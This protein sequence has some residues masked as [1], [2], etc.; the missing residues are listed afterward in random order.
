MLKYKIKSPSRFIVIPP[1]TEGDVNFFPTIR[2]GLAY[3]LYYIN[4]PLVCIILYTYLYT[5][6]N[7][8]YHNNNDDNTIYYYIVCTV[9]Y[10]L[11]I[12]YIYI[13][14]DAPRTGASAR[15]FASTAR[16]GPTAHKPAV[17]VRARLRRCT[18]SARPAADNV[19]RVIGPP[20]SGG[21]EVAR[22]GHVRS[23]Q[24][25]TISCVAIAYFPQLSLI[26]VPIILYIIL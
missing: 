14:A 23:L 24:P 9:S 6:M 18:C 11:R 25:Q 13:P 26:N 19:P 17:L 12:L 15:A 10:K 1:H 7:N 5:K 21:P 8:Y 3:R 4:Y 16:R 22:S 20:R 2:L